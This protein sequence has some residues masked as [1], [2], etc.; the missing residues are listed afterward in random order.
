MATMIEPNKP[1]VG[2]T[3]SREQKK[4]QRARNIAI[5]LV[6]G[7]LCVLFYAMTIVR[8]GPSAF[9]HGS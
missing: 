2:I 1:P 3:L 7:A 6:V 5:G 8:L 9:T 4:R